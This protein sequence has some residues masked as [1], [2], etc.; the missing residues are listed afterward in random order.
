MNDFYRLLLT[1]AATFVV[2]SLLSLLSARIT[3]VI[4]GR[5]TARTS[6]ETD[7]FI[8]QVVVN[9]LKPLGLLISASISWKILPIETEISNAVLGIIKLACLIMSAR[10]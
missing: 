8:L 6:T 5:I 2:G 9:T 7:D 4:F 1:S 10:R 3:R